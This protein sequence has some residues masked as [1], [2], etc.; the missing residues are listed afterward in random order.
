MF[1]GKLTLSIPEV[2]K[3]TGICRTSIYAAINNA[4]L[5]AKKYRA[6][7]LIRVDDLNA[8]LDGLPAY[9][10]PSAGGGKKEAGQP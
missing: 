7:T 8:F 5:R 2:A 6:R 4:K 1:E 3:L 9:P 10:E